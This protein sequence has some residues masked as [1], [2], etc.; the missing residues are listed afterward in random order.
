MTYLQFQVTRAAPVEENASTA[1]AA[2]AEF[3]INHH[4]PRECTRRAV[5]ALA[6][7]GWRA[8]A[9]LNAEHGSRPNEMKLDERLK[10]LFPQAEQ[11]GLV[12]QIASLSAV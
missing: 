10:A 2:A 8:L 3:L 1:E 4:D 5:M 6:E 9:L 11:A 12:Y 7:A